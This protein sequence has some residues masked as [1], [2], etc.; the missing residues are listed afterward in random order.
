MFAFL[1]LH[2]FRYYNGNT[3]YENLLHDIYSYQSQGLIFIC[4]IADSRYWKSE[5]FIAGVD[6]I[7]QHDIAECYKN[8]FTSICTKGSAEV[9]YCLVTHGSLK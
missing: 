9:G 1:T 6:T 2:S 7:G 4:D 5:D 3:F 8:D